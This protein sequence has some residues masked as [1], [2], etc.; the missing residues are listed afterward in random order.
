MSTAS[1]PLIARTE[2]RAAAARPMS[3]PPLILSHRGVHAVA[4]IKQARGEAPPGPRTG[5]SPLPKPTPA[6]GSPFSVSFEGWS[7]T[8]A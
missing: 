1:N 8:S 3:T 2:R 7:R 5:L 4:M 6:G